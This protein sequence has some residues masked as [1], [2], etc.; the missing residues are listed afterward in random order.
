MPPAGCN[1]HEQYQVHVTISLEGQPTAARGR[2]RRWP[3]TNGPPPSNPLSPQPL[4]VEPGIAEVAPEPVRPDNDPGLLAA[5][6][7]RWRILLAVRRPR[8][9][10]SSHR[11]SRSASLSI[12]EGPAPTPR[13]RS[14]GCA[15]SSALPC[16]S[17]RWSPRISRNPNFL[18]NFLPRTPFKPA[19][20]PSES[21]AEQVL[22]Y[23]TRSSTD[24]SFQAGHAGSIPVA[25]S[26]FLAAA[27]E[28]ISRT[29]AGDPSE[30]EAG[31]PSVPVSCPSL[32]CAVLRFLFSGDATLA[33]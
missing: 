27:T 1:T 20:E 13:R 31:V 18:P 22:R 33:R 10:V 3:V 28:V 17:L 19:F 21:L 32:S 5:P 12:S 11:P 9:L 2:G 26:S 23:Y 4:T 25:R 8:Y 24:R 15:E 14:S 6:L 29:C 7:E 16:S 30:R